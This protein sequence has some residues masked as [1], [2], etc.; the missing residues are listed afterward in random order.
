MKIGLIT[1]APPS[2]RYGNRVTAIRW[3]RILRKLGHRVTVSQEYAGEAFDVM[4]ALHARRSHASI[5]RF[6]SE[7][8]AS[9]IIVALTGTDLYKDI[10]TNRDAEESLDV[11]TR[12][13]VLQPRGIEELPA[14]LRYKAR[15]IYQSVPKNATPTKPSEKT[16]DVCVIGHLREVKD[17]FRAAMAA[18][19]LAATSRIR[20]VHVGGAMT[21]EMAERAR[22]EMKINPRYLWVGELA[23]ERTRRI[24]A[25]SR[26]LVLSSKMEG[27]ANVI[28]EA[29]VEGVPVLASR[30]A[31]S[32]GLLGED[33]PGYFDVGDTRGLT[34]L[35]ER[36][37]RDSKFLADLKARVRKLAPMFDP[38]REER[39]WADLLKEV[40]HKNS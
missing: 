2:S 19:R 40:F 31:G 21:D 14:H 5:K 12:I 8:P 34:Q 3:A 26:A 24:L 9:P 30:I 6:S 32:I 22:R 25:H 1:P 11:A 16:F 27:G 36:I 37:E 39:A 7:Q 13:I 4:V 18:R 23:R 35:L 17:P 20:I 38:S 15:V 29:I 10:R 33:Y 28:S